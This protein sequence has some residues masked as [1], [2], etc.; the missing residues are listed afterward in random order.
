MA[1][2]SYMYFTKYLFPDSYIFKSEAQ[3]DVSV[4]YTIIFQNV[5]TEIVVYKHLN[6]KAEA[7]A[8]D[9]TIWF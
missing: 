1:A 2:T 7:K 9:S 8:E 3:I 5:Q 4:L 6:L